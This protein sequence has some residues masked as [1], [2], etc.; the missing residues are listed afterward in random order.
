MKRIA[1]TTPHDF[2]TKIKVD[3]TITVSADV[4]T[5]KTEHS[6][7]DFFFR[8]LEDP[9]F[10]TTAKDT[11]AARIGV[12]MVYTNA[13]DHK[14]FEMLKGVWGTLE[15]AAEY[16]ALSMARS[17][18]ERIHGPLDNALF[19]KGRYALK[20]MQNIEVYRGVDRSDPNWRYNI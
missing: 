5:T 15:I 4:S 18:I 10:G 2:A 19:K 13:T 12:E 7:V 3:D 11:D 6:T 17:E 20:L 16:A 1:L 9:K 14:K 8:V